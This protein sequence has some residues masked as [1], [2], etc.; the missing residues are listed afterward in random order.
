MHPFLAL[1][2]HVYSLFLFF[3]LNLPWVSFCLL[4]YLS[5]LAGRWVT[6]SITFLIASQ[7]IRILFN[8]E[9]DLNNC[10]NSVEVRRN[11]V[12]S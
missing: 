9:R 7:K 6:S 4:F 10:F 5:T 11:S 2:V 8:I 3:I 12:G 1:L